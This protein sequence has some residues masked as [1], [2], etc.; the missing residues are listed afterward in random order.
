MTST[1][2]GFSDTLS[3]WG[4]TTVRSRQVP[5]GTIDVGAWK[6]GAQLFDREGITIRIGDQHADYF[7]TNKVAILRRSGSP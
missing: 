4:L 1:R 3:L 5:Q 2:S 6:M 7:T